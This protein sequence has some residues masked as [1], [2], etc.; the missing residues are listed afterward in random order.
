MSNRQ[1]QTSPS[2]Q[3]SVWA[4]LPVDLWQRVAQAACDARLQKPDAALIGTMR[5]LS[6]MSMVSKSMRTAVTGPGACSLWTRPE[7]VSCRKGLSQLQAQSL[8]RLQIRR[9]QA[10]D[11]ICSLTIYG[12]DWPDAQLGEVC[13]CLLKPVAHVRLMAVHHAHEAEIISSAIAH[14]SVGHLTFQGSALLRLPG[15]VRH[16]DVR[17]RLQ[18]HLG[19]TDTQAIS[20]Q[21]FS[22]LLRLET[23]TMLSLCAPCWHLT[24]Q[25]VQLIMQRLPQLTRLHLGLYHWHDKTQHALQ[26]LQQLPHVQLELSIFA[27]RSSGKRSP[28]WPH[29]I[30]NVLDLPLHHLQIVLPTVALT[31][32]EEDLLSKSIS[33]K[34]LT[35][36]FPGPFQG[37][38]IP[39]PG[40][41]VCYKVI[42]GKHYA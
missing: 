1:R 2:T 16:I 39:P 11:S 5:L 36:W 33:C 24:A 14:S 20:Q 21:L 34:Q 3:S 30:Q 31:P 28:S 29:F 6:T 41:N 26:S 9:C 37:L 12:G 40:V 4:L 19:F 32:D 13:S 18:S 8:N 38:K 23:L 25:H 15:S 7:F 17:V 10:L 42:S 22:Q 35:L 27:K